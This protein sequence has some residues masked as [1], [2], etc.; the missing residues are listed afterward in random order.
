MSAS[1]SPAPSALTGSP[2]RIGRNQGPPPRRIFLPALV[3]VLVAAPPTALGVLAQQP[4]ELSAFAVSGGAKRVTDVGAVIA[5]GRL[6]GK[7]K[8]RYCELPDTTY[9]MSGT[10]SGEAVMTLKVTGD[11][12]LV[13]SAIDASPGQPGGAPSGLAS[14]KADSADAPPPG[15][16]RT[17]QTSG[18]PE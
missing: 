10:M 9:G 16:E 14:M 3:L 7:G 12:R 6:M 5:W 1:T 4:G 18:G 2:V 15:G 17:F 11:C 8:E 13:V